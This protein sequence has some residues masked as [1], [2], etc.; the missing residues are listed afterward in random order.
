MR[1]ALCSSVFAVAGLLAASSLIA[2]NVDPI[3]GTWMLNLTKSTF[4]PGP[5]P[6][7]TTV[8]IEP[9]ENGYKTIQDMVDA[10]GKSTQSEDLIRFDGKQYPFRSPVRPDVPETIEYRRIDA[11]TYERLTRV[12]G[13]VTSTIHVAI[14]PD[15]RTRTSSQT[16]TFSQG[17]GTRNVMV[18]DK[19]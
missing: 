16:G 4:T 8:G 17:P 11:Y 9:F 10:Q 7:S 14:S 18:F 6:K 2:Q 3:V 12:D 1:R 19:Q 5:P 15:G 13:T